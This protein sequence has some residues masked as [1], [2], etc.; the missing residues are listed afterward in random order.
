MW[1]HFAGLVNKSTR[2]QQRWCLARFLGAGVAL[3][4]LVVP[5][6]CVA[7]V[8][9]T[10][11]WFVDP[12][13]YHISAHGQISCQDCHSDVIQR[14]SHP[15]PA[16]VNRKLRDFFKAETCFECHDGAK[17]ERN[18]EKG[19]HGGKPIQRAEDYSNCIACHDPHYQPRHGKKVAAEPA[20]TTQPRDLCA[21]CHEKKQALPEPNGDD[22]R[23]LK[24]H[25]APGTRD[26]ERIEKISRLCLGCHG[27]HTRFTAA[28]VTIPL[29]DKGK[30][31]IKGHKGLACVSCH[32]RAA[33]F[34]HRQQGL[35]DCLQC[36]TPHRESVIHD[37]HSNVSC[38]ACHLEKI[39]PVRD[40][41]TERVVWQ[42]S[43]R[44]VRLSGLNI[45]RLSKGTASCRRCHHAGNRLGAAAMILPAKSLICMPCHAATF[46]AND[47]IS[48]LSLLGFAFGICVVASV[49]FTGT[50]HSQPGPFAVV[51][52]QVK[53]DFLPRAAAFLKALFLDGL[54]Q[55][56]LFIQSR[57]RWIIHALIF[58]PFVVRFSWGLAALTGSMAWPSQAWVWHMLDKN[59]SLTAFVFDLTG[60]MV[61]IGVVLAVLRHRIS[62]DKVVV[63]GLP[64][65]DWLAAGLLGAVVIV[66][67]LLEGIRMAMSPP[68]DGGHWAFVGRALS[69]IWRGTD[70]LTEIYG[71][72]WYLH[73]GLTGAFLLYLPFSGLFHVVM[74]P[75]AA[76]L[77]AADLLRGHQGN[78]RR[79]NRDGSEHG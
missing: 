74:A 17:I 27:R 12:V 50:L 20:S 23:C 37:A 1:C 76:V 78:S 28:S 36:H 51:Q 5:A 10:G 32:L 19:L 55:R 45:L 31:V 44:M 57:R 30:H 40:P 16:Q 15:D 49:W 71:Y 21:K 62:H 73:A 69:L 24:C 22:A 18:L 70:A 34:E 77:N 67:F 3:A 58:W 14:M 54:L 65:R 72:V 52:R 11:S 41:N 25:K 38:Q 2:S 43:E 39:K 13:R 61:I 60:L 66:G 7:D 75:V 6:L 26:S 48:L 59:W 29:I 79:V 47:P 46:S 56:K 63:E 68:A 64:E 53:A 35:P 33:K 4:L 9:M 8:S 42:R